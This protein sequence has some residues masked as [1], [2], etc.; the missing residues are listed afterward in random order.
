MGTTTLRS[1]W[2]MICCSNYTYCS[3][4]NIFLAVQLPKLVV[5]S[6]MCFSCAFKPFK[7]MINVMFLVVAW[8]ES[9]K[10]P[11]SIDTW[12]DVNLCNNPTIVLQVLPFKI[13]TNTHG[14][15]FPERKKCNF[16]KKS[17]TVIHL[18]EISL[19]ANIL[20]HHLSRLSC[21]YL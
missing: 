13:P 3:Q 2:S 11:V 6:L 12:W 9:C 8:R 7:H 5:E 21:N 16:Y 19:N 15:F 20:C 10:T 4:G 14:G 1:L 17:F 18:Y